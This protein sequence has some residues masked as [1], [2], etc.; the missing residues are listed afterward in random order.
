ML[1]WL[2]QQP[3]ARVVEGADLSPVLLVHAGV[4][5]SWTPAQTLALAEEVAVWL[6]GPDL[7]LFL[8][9]MYGNTPA[10]WA[11]SLQGFERLRVI[12][13]TLTR[14]R[15]CTAQ[16]AMEFDT[17]SGPA[18][19]GYMPW[20]DVPGRQ[21]ASVQVAFGH[22]STLG[23]LAGRRDVWSLDSGCVWGGPP[24]TL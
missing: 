3:L 4:Q 8:Q 21:T 18:P 12:V 17:S 13:N 5:P 10:E 14:L 2:R 1:D 16:G 23:W 15:Y 11:D 9:H 6:R 20:F 22:W 24:R 19:A 7:L